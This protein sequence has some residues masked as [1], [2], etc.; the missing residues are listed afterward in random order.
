ML[1]GTVAR[2]D[3]RLKPTGMYSR[4]VPKSIPALP[5]DRDTCPG[6]LKKLDIAPGP[7]RDEVLHPK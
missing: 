7:E 3:A 2:R 1:F 6:A 4:R 5:P